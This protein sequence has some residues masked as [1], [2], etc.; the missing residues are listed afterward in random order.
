MGTA[1]QWQGPVPHDR[2]DGSVREFGGVVVGFRNQ[3]SSFSL[4]V[5]R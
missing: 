2:I 4:D 1:L 5:I 3:T